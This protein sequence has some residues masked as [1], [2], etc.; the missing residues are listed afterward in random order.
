[1]NMKMTKEEAQMVLKALE[2]VAEVTRAEIR[3]LSEAE[4]AETDSGPAVQS[5][6]TSEEGTLESARE[7]SSPARISIAIEVQGGMVRNVY[8]NGNVDVEVYDL[9]VSDF[10]DPDE[11]ENAYSRAT[12]LQ[13]LSQDPTFHRVW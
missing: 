9:D 1:M 7:N 2:H 10:P 4:L 11:A 3:M 6:E 8:A 13:E 5:D 12:A